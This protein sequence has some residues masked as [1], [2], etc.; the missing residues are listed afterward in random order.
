MSRKTCSAVSEAAGHYRAGRLDEAESLYRALLDKQP[1][2]VDAILGLAAL[3][4]RRGHAEEALALFR[5]AIT[6]D[7]ESRVADRQLGRLLEQRGDLVGAAICYRRAVRLRPGDAGAQADLARTL[8][9]QGEAPAIGHYRRALSLAPDGQW[10]MR[11]QVTSSRLPSVRIWP[12]P[13]AIWAKRYG[14]WGA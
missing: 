9:G 13:T 8:A 2:N 1:H 11:R 6:L 10:P 4:H 12:K 3:R 7:P 5:R 14:G